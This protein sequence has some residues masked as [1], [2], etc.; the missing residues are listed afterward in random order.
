MNPKRKI[1][2]HIETKID[3]NGDCWL[4]TGELSGSG[5]GRAWYNGVRVAAHRVVYALYTGKWCEGRELDHRCTV[6]NCVNPN[7]LHPVTHKQNCRL[8]NKRNRNGV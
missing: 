5:Y 6:R 2:K 1:P 4:W 3:R 7:H 8:R